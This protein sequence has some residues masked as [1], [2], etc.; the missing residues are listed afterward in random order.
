MC[1]SSLETESSA[2]TPARVGVAGPLDANRPGFQTLPW[3][4]PPSS[5]GAGLLR[6]DMDSCEDCG[7]IRHP[8]DMLTPDADEWPEVAGMVYCRFC[9][10]HIENEIINERWLA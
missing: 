10:E 9:W 5:L 4:G 3:I 7:E 2:I 1:L 8:E 6:R